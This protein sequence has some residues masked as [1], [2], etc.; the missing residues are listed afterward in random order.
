MLIILILTVRLQ[1]AITQGM[2]ERKLLDGIVAMA[3]I[4]IGNNSSG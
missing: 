3:G 2:L 1:P 4:I